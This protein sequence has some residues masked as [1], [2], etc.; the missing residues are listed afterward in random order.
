MAKIRTTIHRYVDDY[1]AI[2]PTAESGM[3]IL[4]AVIIAAG[5]GGLAVL[6]VAAADGKVS[7]FLET[8]EGL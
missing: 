6:V 5:L 8:L 1:R 4:Q 7:E 2:R 3:E